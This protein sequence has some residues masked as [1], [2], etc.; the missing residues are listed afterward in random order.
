MPRQREKRLST[1]TAEISAPLSQAIS[2]SLFRFN[3]A[4]LY[5]PWRLFDSYTCLL[6]FA[7]SLECT[8]CLFWGQNVKVYVPLAVC[9]LVGSFGS[10]AIILRYE[11]GLRLLVPP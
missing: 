1:S 6:C 8:R 10:A 9:I 11:A 7:A 3:I 2:T 5:E 4:S